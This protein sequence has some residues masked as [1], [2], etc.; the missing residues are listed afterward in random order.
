LLAFEHA[1]NDNN[2]FLTGFAGTGKTY[3]LRLVIIAKQI[4]YGLDGVH[5]IAT[6]KLVANNVDGVTFHKEFKLTKDSK[7]VGGFIGGALDNMFRYHA[8]D[9]FILKD[10]V[11][12]IIIDEAGMLSN[13]D[14]KFID[15]FYRSMRISN[16]FF[17]GVIMTLCGDVLQL[18]CINDTTN[19]RL[20]YFFVADSFCKGSF[21][22]AY[23]KSGMR[24]KDQRVLVALNRVRIGD[25]DD[26]LLRY[27]NAEWGKSILRC[28]VEY[29]LNILNDSLHEEYQMAQSNKE[30]NKPTTFFNKMN[31]QWDKNRVMNRLMYPNGWS[32][33][34]ASQQI[35]MKKFAANADEMNSELPMVVCTEHVDLHAINVVCPK[36]YQKKY[37]IPD[38]K[39]YN[40]KMIKCNQR[41]ADLSP[42][43][44][45]E[46]LTLMEMLP[47]TF[48]S[49]SI[50]KQIS[51]NSSGRI[52][53]V[54]VENNI[55]KSVKIKYLYK[56]CM[57][58]KEILKMKWYPDSNL[59]DSAY[60]Y[61][62]FII[63]FSIT[64]LRL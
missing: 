16:K 52:S 44:F 40:V 22:V 8:F 55:V 34:Y 12:C 61:G 21:T 31:Y 19:P 43:P 29:L 32:D 11:K 18:P 35:Y 9:Y 15:N 59:D 49:N 63:I 14:I 60:W 30:N 58:E 13:D 41:N 57:Y 2:V 46:T 51:N 37:N 7:W 4:K 42:C 26:E 25:V 64:Y 39:V 38:N 50:D 10:K 56:G 5:V 48:K 53:K 3:L 27:I 62:L 17:G 1:I 33:F 20:S 47:I 45:S 24:Q 36:F 6:T 28:N 23:L 54:N